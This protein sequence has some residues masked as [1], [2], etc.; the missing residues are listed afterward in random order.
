MRW[1]PDLHAGQDVEQAGQG[2]AMQT[3]WASVPLAGPPTRT[4]GVARLMQLA[5]LRLPI[6]VRSAGRQ[7]VRGTVEPVLQQ[8]SAVVPP[9]QPVSLQPHCW[10]GDW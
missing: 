8:V 5:F 4:A 2:A 9:E 10:V 7:L 3:A 6:E 1:S